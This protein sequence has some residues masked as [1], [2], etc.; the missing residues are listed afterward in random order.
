M[1]DNVCEKNVTNFAAAPLLAKPKVRDANFELLRIVSML[2]IVAYHL[3]GRGGFL[4][5]STGASHVILTIIRVICTICVN[6]FVLITCWF[7]VEKKVNYKKLIRLWVEVFFY[8]VLILLVSVICGWK[9][10]E[11]I[12][13]LHLVPVIS[14]KYWFITSYFIFFLSIPLLNAMISNISKKQHFWFCVGITVFCF[15]SMI[16]SRISPLDINRGFSPIWFMCLFIFISFLKK[17]N[18]K[19]LK[20]WVY[21]FGFLIASTISY[22]AGWYFYSSPFTLLASICFFM[23]FKKIK[24]KNLCLSKVIAFIS[25]CTLGVYLIHD[26]DIL[27]EYMYSNILHT[28]KFFSSPYAALIAIGFIFAIFVGCMII[29]IARQYLF[30]F[31]EFIFRKIRSKKVK[32]LDPPT[33]E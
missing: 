32:Q 11:W 15:A 24:I 16:P 26:N 18:V 10:F 33:Q 2:M 23:M 13:L 22:F 5:G 31:V 8:S 27:R 9:S 29:D 1:E 6:L 14:S 12:D 21:F 4:D 25:S 17:Y 30:K 3:L 28:E 7:V 19:E 20:W